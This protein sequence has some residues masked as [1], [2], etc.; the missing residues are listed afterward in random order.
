[1]KYEAGNKVLYNQVPNK[2]KCIRRTQPLRNG[3]YSHG[4]I[5]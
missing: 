4:L 3:V 1:M 5:N 2:K